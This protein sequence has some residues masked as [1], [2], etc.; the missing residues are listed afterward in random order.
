MG[1]GPWL[2]PE[3]MLK[4]SSRPEQV[5]EAEK[6][7]A[8]MPVNS[9]T[10][11]RK[12][13]VSVVRTVVGARRDAL[14]RF[15]ELRITLL[16]SEGKCNFIAITGAPVLLLVDFGFGSMVQS[17]LDKPMSRLDEGFGGNWEKT[18]RKFDD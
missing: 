12:L 6:G 16:F 7:E 13:E 3:P 9:W 4:K 11:A 5:D 1:L 15:F 14:V 18:S 17:G 8:G 10:I 2:I